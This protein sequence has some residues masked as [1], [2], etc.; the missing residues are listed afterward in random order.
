MLLISCLS[1]ISTNSTKSDRL[2]SSNLT[3]FKL[4]CLLLLSAISPSS[5]KSFV[6]ITS[7]Y[8]SMLINPYANP[9]KD[10]SQYKREIFVMIKII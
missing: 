2:T 9:F 7:L 8:L 6:K 1:Y 10:N 3:S 5:S 4:I